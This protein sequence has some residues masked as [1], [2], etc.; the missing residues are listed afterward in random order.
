MSEQI[1]GSQRIRVDFYADTFRSCVIEVSESTQRLP[2][3]MCN[4]K[5][6]LDGHYYERGQIIE[7]NIKI[8]MLRQGVKEKISIITAKIIK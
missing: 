5:R 7:N 3:C 8:A 4:L 6:I 1:I 2:A